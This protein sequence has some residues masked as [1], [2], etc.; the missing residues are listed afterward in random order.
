[1]RCGRNQRRPFEKGENK[2]MERASNTV[3]RQGTEKN[4]IILKHSTNMCYLCL[5]LF[6]FL[7]PFFLF[8]VL[9]FSLSSFFFPITFSFFRFW[10]FPLSFIV[11]FVSDCLTCPLA[12]YHYKTKFQFNSERKQYDITFTD[13]ILNDVYVLFSLFNLSV[14][15]P[16]CPFLVLYFLVPFCF[17]TK[18][19]LILILS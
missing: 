6:A 13:L 9:P 14:L 3:K 4:T 18:C 16:L 7:F 8:I 10:S 17:E 2:I 12:S 1:M 19:K 15:L 5:F 11:P